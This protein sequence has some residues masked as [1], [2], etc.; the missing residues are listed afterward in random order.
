MRVIGGTA[1]GRKLASLKGFRIRPTQDHIRESLF[2]ILAPHIDGASILD[3]FAGTG[4][5]GIEGLSRGAERCTFV[6]SSYKCLSVIKQNL[7]ATGFMERGT[8]LKLNLPTKLPQVAAQGLAY[9]VIFS[10]PPYNFE[11]YGELLAA[12]IKCNLLN[13]N[14]L[15]L[16]E[17]SARGPV[18][19]SAGSL[20]LVRRAEYGETHVS[21]FS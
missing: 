16:L 15:L 6:E 2:N 1:K 17:H 10:D 12:V 11:K 9:D 4:A 13:D 14:G 5:L 21:F 19:E 18:I 3:L 20:K 7:T 8:L